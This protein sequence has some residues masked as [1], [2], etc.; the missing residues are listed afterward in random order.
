MIRFLREVWADLGRS[1]FVGERYE[2]NIRGISIGAA[3]IV[4]VNLITGSLNLKQGNLMGAISSLVLIVF[5][6]IVF[7]FIAIRKNRKTAL[8]ITI[9]AVILIY[10]YDVIAV[11][12]PIMP[13]WTILFSWAFSYLVSVK[14]DI[15]LSAY[16]SALYIVLF[17]SPLRQLVEGKYP[18][19]FLE[20][21][22]ILFLANSFLCI[23]IMV[24]YH[25]NTLHQMEYAE[26]L[27]EAKSDF[28]I[29]SNRNIYNNVS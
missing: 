8:A 7:Y 6:S 22:P 26:Q 3:M 21:F 11:T 5:F 4:V 1:I 2:K 27:L 24:Q 9:F 15:G 25:R 29:S 20:V 13:V 14:A 16:F 10:S 17:Y 23:Y 12:S 18:E 28:C 19:A